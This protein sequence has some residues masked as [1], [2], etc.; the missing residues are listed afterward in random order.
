MSLDIVLLLFLVNNIQPKAVMINSI[1]LQYLEF[2]HPLTFNTFT[3]TSDQDRISPDNINTIS[4]RQVMR[5]GK[6]IN[7]EII[8]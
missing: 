4:S 1:C 7:Y 5:I 2:E 3:P 6:N 8:S